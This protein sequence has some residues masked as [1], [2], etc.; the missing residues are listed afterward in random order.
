MKLLNLTS[1]L[2][3]SACAANVATRVLPREDATVSVIS[4]ARE[5]S[6]AAGANIETANRY[7]KAKDGEAVFLDEQSEYQGVLTRSGEDAA[8][9]AKKIPVI[10]DSLT[11][12]EDYRVTTRF[13]C[14]PAVGSGA[15]G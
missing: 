10:G 6:T 3:L 11:S 14:L 8:R 4:V 12:D 9:V 5:E 7:C 13:K 15:S 2:V 1:V